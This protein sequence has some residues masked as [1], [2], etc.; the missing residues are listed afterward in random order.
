MQE[1]QTESEIE[2]KLKPILGIRPGVY[3]TILYS[4]IILAVLFFLL[5]FPGLTNPGSMLIVKT[6]PAGAAIRVN[7]IY[8]GVAGSRIFVPKGTHT[9]EAVMPGFESQNAVHEIPSR[10]FGSRF[11]PRI[12]RTEFALTT[13]DPAAAF[14]IYAADFTAWT[15]AGEPTASWQIPLSLSEGAYRTGPYANDELHQILLAAAGFTTTRAAMRDLIRA[16]MLMDNFGNAPSVPALF[17]SV[18]EILA[19]LSQNPESAAWLARLLPR[20][21]AAI[22]EGSDWFRNEPIRN[23]PWPETNNPGRISAAGL[24]FIN[25]SGSGLIISETAVPRSLFETFLNENPEYLDQKTDYFP[26][27]LSSHPWEI[28]RNIITGI[29]WYAADAFCKWLTQRLPPAMSG[30]KVRLPTEQEWLFAAQRLNNMKNQGWEWCEDPYSPLK[31]FTASPEAVK[32]LGSPERTLYGRPY[33]GSAETRASLP[34][35]LSS[36]FVSFRTVIASKE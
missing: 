4:L 34:P 13:A 20:E 21:T 9:I 22:I 26:Q 7:D 3:L 32:K 31:F 6:E 19:F 18:S 33:S 11:F 35:D 27:E 23:T 28:D 25:F 17:G 14:A 30:M 12:Y 36:P 5:L 1:K 15:F 2:V 24:T 29:T 16:K 10:L 8:M